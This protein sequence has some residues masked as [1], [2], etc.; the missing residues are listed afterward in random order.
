MLC[1]ATIY[2]IYAGV[3]HINVLHF[4]KDS[5]STLDYFGLGQYIEDQ[6]VGQHQGNVT[7]NMS[8]NRI[9]VVELAGTLD[10]YDHPMTVHG[11]L[12][13]SNVYVP[14]V[15]AVFKLA[16][17]T[18]GRHGRGRHHQGGYGETCPFEQG[19]WNSSMQT[20]L[21]NV[22]DA[23]QTQWTGGGTGGTH[24][25][26]VAVAPRNATTSDEAHPVISIIA[27]SKIGTINTRKL[28][29]GL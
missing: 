18:A 24:G 27:S 7:S 9:H 12:G 5:A 25:W 22:A 20:R 26:E 1:R 2:G 17:H 29:R 15:S 4:T 19:L 28:G 21:D 23:L 16:T 11:V 14:F 6:W 3:G 8:W 10:A 13:A